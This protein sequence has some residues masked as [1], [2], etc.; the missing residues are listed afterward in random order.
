M[1]I[2]TLLRRLLG[3]NG[4]LETGGLLSGGC[5]DSNAKREFPSDK[6]YRRVDRGIVRVEF[7]SPRAL[8]SSSSKPVL[9][10]R[11][12]VTLPSRHRWLA[13]GKRTGSCGRGFSVSR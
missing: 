4:G 1:V 11:P 2:F 12:V 10:A 13:P 8:R 6:V 9:D 5:G 3:T 7:R